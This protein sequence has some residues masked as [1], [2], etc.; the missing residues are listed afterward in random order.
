MK[1]PFNF[2]EIKVKVMQ[3]VKIIFLAI[4]FVLF[5][6]QTSNLSHIVAYGKANKFLTSKVKDEGQGQGKGQNNIFVHNFGSICHTD[7]QLISYCSLLKGKSCMTLTLT[8]DL[9][10]NKFPQG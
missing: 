8:F 2:L 10:L 9:D 1:L 7:F 3:K 6:I 4:T 5:V